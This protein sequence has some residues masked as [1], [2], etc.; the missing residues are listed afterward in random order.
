VWFIFVP[1]MRSWIWRH[2]STY[3]ALN[4]RQMWVDSFTHR[5]LYPLWKRHLYTSGSVWTLWRKERVPPAGNRTWFP[6]SDIL[7]H[8]HSA[9]LV[10]HN[11]VHWVDCNFNYM[12]IAQ[13][14]HNYL[15][16]QCFISF[17]PAPQMTCH[18]NILV[19]SFIYLIRITGA[20]ST[21]SAIS[22]L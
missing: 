15:G 22:W 17:F 16:L 21:F 3:L 6:W 7:E 11:F 2:N 14:Q 12:S 13:R 20:I 9:N 18:M 1:W 19:Y 8:S 5:P 4:I 10:A